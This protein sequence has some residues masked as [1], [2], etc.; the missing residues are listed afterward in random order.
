MCTKICDCNNCFKNKTCTSCVL[1]S[2]VISKK[3]IDC[4][5]DG[6]QGCPYKVKF[7]HKNKEN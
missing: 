2:E 4:Q 5:R 7:P 6:I 1:Q 3:E